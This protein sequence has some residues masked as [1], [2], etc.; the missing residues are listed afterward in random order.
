M[1]CVECT[2]AGITELSSRHKSDYIRLTLCPRCGAVADKYVEFDNVILFLDVML[3]KPQA[4][5]HVAYNGTE[6]EMAAGPPGA[7]GRAWWRRAAAALRTHRRLS[8]LGVMYILF[9]VYLTWAYEEKSAAHAEAIR[10]VLAQ[11]I[12]LQYLYFIL[13]L[14][15]E[16]ATLNVVVQTVFRGWL[17]WG[18]TRSCNL[19]PHQQRAYALA[20]LLMTVLTA[21]LIRLFPILML[22][23]PYDATASAA[24]PLLSVVAFLNTVEAL[25]VVTGRRYLALVVTMAVATAAQQVVAAVV[26]AAVVGVWLGRGWWGVWG[27]VVG[28][29]VVRWHHWE[30]VLHRVVEGGLAI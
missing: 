28:G 22:I 1:I 13:K 5:R 16:V 3:L 26:L 6:A 19:A 17:Q 23:W 21:G 4:Y 11:P 25:R 9:E 20:V 27:E 15:T 2:Y 7:P 30:G 10:F 24:S 18:A 8:R 14:L 29:W 12:H